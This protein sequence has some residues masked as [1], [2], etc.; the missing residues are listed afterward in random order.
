MIGL[1]RDNIADGDKDNIRIWNLN[2]V[3]QRD[4]LK[5]SNL[6][7]LGDKGSGKRSLV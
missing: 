7:I 6:L 1:A 5:E 4:E 3:A 2:E